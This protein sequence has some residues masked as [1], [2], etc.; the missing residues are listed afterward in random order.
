MFVSDDIWGYRLV[1]YFC[2]GP[3]CQT[4]DT[5]T[6]KSGSG[7]GTWL[8]LACSDGQGQARPALAQPGLL[9][10]QC[11]ITSWLGASSEL[12]LATRPTVNKLDP[13][14]SPAWAQSPA[15]I[16]QQSEATVGAGEQKRA[17][18]GT[19]GYQLSAELTTKLLTIK[20]FVL[21]GA[22]LLSKAR[23]VKGDSAHSLYT[24]DSTQQFK[25]KGEIKIESHTLQM[26]CI[27]RHFIIS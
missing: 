27:I 6:L 9:A 10:S 4:G 5:V 16:M 18:S 3:P 12:G 1:L 26:N 17:Q 8:R 7:S 19:L 23:K 22:W 24:L 15:T 2:P 13:S 25:G 11:C 21:S 14:R 20:W